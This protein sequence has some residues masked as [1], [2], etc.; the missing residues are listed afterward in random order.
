MFSSGR[1]EVHGI[2][3][4][5][6]EILNLYFYWR[7]LL[8]GKSCENGPLLMWNLLA[9]FR[10]YFYLFLFCFRL[11]YLHMHFSTVSSE[12][13]VLPPHLLPSQ[14]SLLEKTIFQSLFTILSCTYRS[15]IW[16]PPRS[17]TCILLNV[18]FLHQYFR[19]FSHL[20]IQSWVAP[21]FNSS[22]VK[23]YQS[24]E[25]SCMLHF[26]P[27]IHGCPYKYS[28]FIHPYFILVIFKTSDCKWF[29]F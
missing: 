29:I 12:T 8:W 13:W 2:I 3:N 15:G 10:K 20:V 5:A 25:S 28:V 11:Q 23:L 1:A 4:S 18:V 27:C 19:T 14:Y 7:S 6:P 26:N 17:G 9:W 21:L 24:N 16:K 22:N